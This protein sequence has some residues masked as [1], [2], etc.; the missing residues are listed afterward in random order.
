MFTTMFIS[1]WISN[2]AT[3]AM[4]LPIVD[5]VAQ[6]IN[7]KDERPNMENQNNEAV[8]KQE[9]EHLLQD[10]GNDIPSRLNLEFNERTEKIIESETA[11]NHSDETTLLIKLDDE[12]FEER[13]Q[14]ITNGKINSISQLK[15]LTALDNGCGHFDDLETIAE[16]NSKAKLA[17][18]ETPKS[19]FKRTRT[20][21]KLQSKQEEQKEI[22]KR[23]N[24]D[25]NT[26]KKLVAITSNPTLVAP[27]QVKLVEDSPSKNSSLVQ[28]TDSP[29]A[30][31]D[32]NQSK[33]TLTTPT[34]VSLI[35]LTPS[36]LNKD[37]NENEEDVKE[38]TQRNFLL[39]GIAFAANIGGTGVITGTPPNLVV[40]DVLRKY[41]EDTG[42]TFASWMAFAIPV[43]VINIFFAWLWLQRLLRWYPGGQDKP[44]KQKEEKAMKAINK[45]YEELGEMSQHEIQVLI[46]FIALIFMWFF[47]TPIFMPGWGDIFT[48]TSSTGA[49]ISVAQ[50][51]P[52]IFTCIMLFILPQNIISGHFQKVV[53]ALRTPPL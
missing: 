19:T 22:R 49:N 12:S 36:N 11:V 42:L 16:V 20:M 14:V 44:S 2:T 15:S 38:E 26:P 34:H 18:I 4:M 9:E 52:A 17:D 27:L 3:T 51:T 23:L 29:T 33:P 8:I 6:A 28:S 53:K 35:K 5:A 46:L 47:K 45:K 7:Q 50:A 32:L 41:G 31:E 39:L 43:M 48:V 30:K 40:P 21:K 24:S 37:A 10:K 25:A 1:M 13:L